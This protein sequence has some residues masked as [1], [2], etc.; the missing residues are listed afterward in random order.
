M[1]GPPPKRT[2]FWHDFTPEERS[3]LR[4]AIRGGRRWMHEFNDQGRKGSPRRQTQF[5]PP[6]HRLHWLGEEATHYGA[7]SEQRGWCPPYA[8]FDVQYNRM[9]ELQ[10]CINDTHL[11]LFVVMELS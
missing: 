1:S 6:D 7:C 4:T 5:F 11:K 3:T 8:T 2:W 9:A 10:L